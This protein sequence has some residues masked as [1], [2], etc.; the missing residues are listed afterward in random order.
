MELYKKFI[1]DT[2]GLRRLLEIYLELRQHF[3]ELGFTESDL[4]SPP[5]YTNKM[6]KLFHSFGD[7]QNDLFRQV[8]DYGF[9]I[10]WNDFI[11]Y[12]KPILQK[13]NDITPLKDGNS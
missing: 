13:I 4:S 3:Q 1:D 9:D 5:T 11:E 7:T 12:L 8:N 2:V 10:T 6:M